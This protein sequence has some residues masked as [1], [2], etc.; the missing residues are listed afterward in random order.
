MQESEENHLDEQSA[1]RIAAWVLHSSQFLSEHKLD[2][3]A[4]FL[5]DDAM[6]SQGH[7]WQTT[8]TGQEKVESNCF[9]AVPSLFG[10]V[11]LLRPH[12]K[13]EAFPPN[14]LNMRHL[15]ILDLH[16][17]FIRQI[18]SGIHKLQRLVKLH[19]HDNMLSV[20]PVEIGALTLLEA[21]TL[22]KNRIVDLP[23]TIG[24]LKSLQLLLLHDNLIRALPPSMGSLQKLLELRGKGKDYCSRLKALLLTS[25]F[26]FEQRAK[27]NSPFCMSFSGGFRALQ[28]SISPSAI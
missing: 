8:I 1:R 24:N 19:L 9:G 21:L 4:D 18:P 14:A 15:R 25:P 20:V 5:V 3:P 11:E 6:I 16:T 12:C 26:F 7:R 10:R 27:T 23:S 17:N 2:A 22:H 28:D 13:L